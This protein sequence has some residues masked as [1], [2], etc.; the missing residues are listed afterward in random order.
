[1][2]LSYVVNGNDTPSTSD[3]SI[4]IVSSAAVEQGQAIS[5]TVMPWWPG[6]ALVA[7]AGFTFSVAWSVRPPEEAIATTLLVVTVFLASCSAWFDYRHHRIPNTLTISALLVAFL[8]HG[9][10][11]LITSIDVASDVS[12]QTRQPA[13]TLSPP[14]TLSK[15][16]P[17]QPSLVEPL[18]LGLS[19]VG[20]ALG[21][22][23]MLFVFLAGGCGGGD[24]KIAAAYGALVGWE[25]MV[26]LL[27]FGH[28]LAVGAVIASGIWKF[29][30]LH[31]PGIAASSIAPLLRRVSAATAEKMKA[32]AEEYAPQAFRSQH[33]PM[34]GF[35]A[36]GW[37]LAVALRQL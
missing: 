32:W 13:S 28:L 31:L 1:M 6:V 34:A 22:G 11:G 37:V 10:T 2:D 3:A 12:V 19:L 20:A 14:S 5:A 29:G 23:L 26:E 17:Q 9:A 18:P 25:T 21:F 27:I 8:L 7:I 16:F 36:L 4:K 15:A 35:F 33:I 24:V 30:P